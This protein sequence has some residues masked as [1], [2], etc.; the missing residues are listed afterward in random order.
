M[1]KTIIEN[2]GVKCLNVHRNRVQYPVKRIGSVDKPFRTGN[3]IVYF[4]L[5]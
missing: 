4:P 3:I 2:G 1:P 5:R